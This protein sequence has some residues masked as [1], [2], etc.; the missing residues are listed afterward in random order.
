VTSDNEDISWQRLEVYNDSSMVVAYTSSD[1]FTVYLYK[2]VRCNRKTVIK[3][4][5][6]KSWQE[7]WDA[8][9]NDYSNVTRQ[10]YLNQ[11]AI[12]KIDKRYDITEKINDEN[13]RELN[14]PKLILR[15]L[16]QYF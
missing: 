4:V 14:D 7:Y 2:I 3:V 8:R 12:K 15:K 6:I 11:R 13:G 1:Y 5:E 9:N 16:R 10:F